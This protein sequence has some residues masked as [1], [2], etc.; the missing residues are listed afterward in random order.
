LTHRALRSEILAN[1]EPLIFD[2]LGEA[3]QV[4][5]ELESAFALQVQQEYACAVHSGTVGLFLALR[6]C[7]IRPGDQV[8]TVGNSDVSTTAAISHCGAI[9]VLC[10]VRERDYTMDPAAVEPLISDQ[11]VALLPVDLYGHPADTMSLRALADEH[12]LKIVEDA[13]LAT[14]ARDHGKSVGAYADV[15]LFSFA[16]F[17]PLGCAGNGGMLVTSD[18]ELADR[19]RL[20]CSYGHALD[21]RPDLHG[22]QQHVIE[23]YNVPLDPLQA[24]LLQV[25][26]PHLDKWTEKRRQIASAYAR[27]LAGTTAVLPAFRPQSEPTYR[28]YTV[29][30]PDRDRI[31]QAMRAAGIEVVLHYAPP[32]YRQ[33]VYPSGLIGSDALPL[34]D[35]LAREILCL[36]VTVELTDDEVDYVVSTLRNLL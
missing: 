27:G 13:A 26:L 32:V 25:K 10:E 18:S 3:N 21:V 16:P 28:S 2:Q 35:R 12:G 14:G 17:K 20:L 6:A 8:I 30:V 9:P 7:G 36:P 19:I 5:L 11:T 22:H 29:R 31:Y 33:P 34:T 24:A 23:G 15:T 4:R 1:I